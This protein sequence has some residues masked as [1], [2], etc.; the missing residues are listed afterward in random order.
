MIEEHAGV[1]EPALLVHREDPAIAQPR[2]FPVVAER[3][4]LP[5]TEVQRPGRGAGL[6][7]PARGLRAVLEA[8]AVVRERRHLVAGIVFEAREIAVRDGGELLARVAL[9]RRQ[10][11]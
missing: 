2:V 7:R 4:R 6:D 5:A 1:D 8:E 10:R 9:V 3:E 11:S